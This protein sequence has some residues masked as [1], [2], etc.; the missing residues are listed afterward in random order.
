MSDA[1]GTARTA[2]AGLELPQPGQRWRHRGTH[3]VYVVCE[4]A[5]MRLP[6]SGEWR[7]AVAARLE[8]GGKLK[9][10]CLRSWE[11]TFER[12]PDAAPPAWEEVG[13]EGWLL[14]LPGARLC[15]WVSSA[16]WARP[17]SLGAVRPVSG[18][19]VWAWQA[20]GLDGGE[21]APATESSKWEFPT[22]EAAQ[23][24]AEAWAAQR[25]KGATP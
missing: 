18:A 13:P 1:N 21:D 4:D 12:L 16:F 23:A 17:N 3:G 25:Q 15:L 20:D 24:A 9:V 10:R 19:P 8:G 7:E 5:D 11:V 22:R 6:G 14:F 2:P